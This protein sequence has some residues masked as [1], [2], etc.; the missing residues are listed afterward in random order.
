MGKRL[1]R[2][3]DLPKSIITHKPFVIFR[4][5]LQE[6]EGK[7]YMIMDYL[8]FYK[9]LVVN[10]AYPDG[11]YFDEIPKDNLL[12]FQAEAFD[13]RVKKMVISNTYYLNIELKA[14]ELRFQ[15][16]ASKQV[17]QAYNKANPKNPIGKGEYVHS[18]TGLP[19]FFHEQ[20]VI[21]IPPPD[22]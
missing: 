8:Y 14:D 15:M 19:M 6:H 22:A 17:I 21:V 1:K 20:C 16:E 5:H 10:S 18:D 12:S 11:T 9:N 13:N 4:P 2:L 3:K 7:Q